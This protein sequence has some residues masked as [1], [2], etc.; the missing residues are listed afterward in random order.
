MNILLFFDVIFFTYNFL[1][2]ADKIFCVN[3]KE[4]LSLLV[5]SNCR[6]RVIFCRFNLKHQ[7]KNISMLVRIEKSL[8]AS[9]G[10]L[11][12]ITILEKFP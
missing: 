11:L 8:G 9:A 2:I 3:I 12:G 1:L 4:L 5:N 7:I 10:T 6:K